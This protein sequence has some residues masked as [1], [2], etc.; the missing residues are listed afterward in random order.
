MQAR[1]QLWRYLESPSTLNSETAIMGLQSSCG[2]NGCKSGHPRSVK[3][4][5]I[6]ILQQ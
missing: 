1:I 3:A 4:G 5:A 2:M 6:K